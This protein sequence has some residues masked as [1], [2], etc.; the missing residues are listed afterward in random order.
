MF[1]EAISQEIIPVQPVHKRIKNFS[2]VSLGFTKKQATEEAM[3]CPQP[4]KP[5]HIHRCPLG[6]DIFGFIRYVREGD[7]VRALEKIREH[8]PL[9]AICGRI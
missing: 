4:I 6:T 9:A 2:E 5:E 7:P 8:N 3:R 1:K